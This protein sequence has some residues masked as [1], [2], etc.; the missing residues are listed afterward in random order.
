MS[1]TPPVWMEAR[2]ES[3]CSNNGDNWMQPEHCWDTA[4][5]GFFDSIGKARKHFKAAKWE[6]V[7]DGWW[8]PVCAKLRKQ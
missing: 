1:G 2:C 4:E 8:C 5:G 6:I 7:N 3:V